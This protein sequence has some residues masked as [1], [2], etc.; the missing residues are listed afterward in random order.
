MLAR[1]NK[2][3]W[4]FR[5]DVLETVYDGEVLHEECQDRNIHV[6][7]AMIASGTIPRNRLI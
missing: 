5:L 6:G 3:D 7:L 1:E 2:T 4:S